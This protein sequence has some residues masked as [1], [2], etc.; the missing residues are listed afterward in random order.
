MILNAAAYCTVVARHTVM[1]FCA[2]PWFSSTW[3]TS[4]TLPSMLLPLRVATMLEG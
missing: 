2:A 4:E 1:V 3:S